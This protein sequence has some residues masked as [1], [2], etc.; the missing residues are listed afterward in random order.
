MIRQRLQRWRSDLE[1]RRSVKDLLR[2]LDLAPPLDVRQLCDRLGQH[3][4]RS[5]RLVPRALP[6]PGTFGLWIA[7]ADTDWILY[8]RDTTAAHQ[9]HI[10]LHEIG[11]IISGH[12][13]NEHDDDLLTQLFPDIPPE[14]VH[15]AL[16]RD[17]YDTAHEH[18]AEM[19]ATVIKDWAGLLDHLQ[20]AP[21]RSRL[22]GAFDDHQGWL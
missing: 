18:Q 15:R 3:R 8:Q 12:P 5:I 10:I 14:I 13:S 21:D 9:D 6:T 1:L 11:H 19:A 4:D 22:G 17:G 7:T 20:A 16:R 2:E